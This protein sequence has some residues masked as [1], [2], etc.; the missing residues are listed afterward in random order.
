MGFWSSSASS[1]SQRLLSERE[2]FQ[3]MRTK[4]TQTDVRFGWFEHKGFTALMPKPTCRVWI[5]I[6][7][8]KSFAATGSWTPVPS[9]NGGEKNCILVSATAH[10][11]SSPQ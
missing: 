7:L 11:E 3:G 9:G 5:R 4:P 8:P 1:A 6:P 10:V 2:D